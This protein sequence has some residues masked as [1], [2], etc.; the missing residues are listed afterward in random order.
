MSSGRLSLSLAIVSTLGSLALAPAPPVPGP[1]APSAGLPPIAFVSRNPVL[2]EDGHPESGAIPGIGLRD[3]TARVG[4][5]LLVREPD[6]TLRVLVAPPALFDVADPCVS[7]DGAKI[8][9]SGLAHPDSSWRIFEIA[10]E[11]SG[12]RQVTRSDRAISL[13][14]FGAAAAR[15]TRY[16]DIDPCWFPDGRICFASTRYPMISEFG[17]YLA[18]NLFVAG[19]DGAHPRRI[20]T[21]RGSG[22]EPAFDPITGRLVYSRWLIN[23]DRPSNASRDG[24]TYL[25]EQALTT[26][27]GNVWQ[28]I[29]VTP[30]GRVP[31]LHAGDPRSRVGLVC[32]KPALFPDGRVLTVFAANGAFAPGPGATGIRLFAPGADAGRTVIGFSPE[33]LAALGDAKESPVVP[34]APWATDP[35]PLPDG[36]LVVSLAPTTE[37]DFGL[38]ACGLDGSGLEP[39][40]DLPGTLELDAA[41]IAPRPRP[42]VLAGLVDPNTSELPPTED[43]ATFLS[44]GTYRFDCYNVFMNAPVD[45]PIPDAPPIVRGARIRFYMNFQRQNPGGRDPSILFREA[46]ISARG[47]IYENGMPADVPFFGQVVDA[48][49]RVVVGPTGVPAHVAEFGF[50]RH[51]GWAQCVGCH[52]G[53]SVMVIPNNFTKSEWFNVSTSA[54]VEASSEWKPRGSTA[55]PCPGRRVVDRRARNDSLE[56]AWVAAGRGREW[57]TLRWQIPIEVTRFV[58]YGIHSNPANGTDVAVEDCRITLLR[59]GVPV[60]QATA[61]AIAPEG[62]TVN[63]PATVIDSARIEVLRSRGLVRGEPRTGLAEVETIARL[64]LEE[65]AP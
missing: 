16:D 29:S 44:C 17:D 46:P 53:H 54:S 42:P 10:A 47:A 24:L 64:T 50:A 6:G 1:G 39:L 51:G 55:P 23:L 13:L 25:D 3:R 21:E 38:Y 48:R 31:K 57:V 33:A 28:T 52:V 19:T 60:G 56:V 43:P 58:L 26:D 5:R 32:Y 41:V 62:T 14:Q 12:L 2:D 8:V 35:E 65:P 18:T 63:V 45:A 27:V 9:F 22:E 37:G 36:R 40:V 11:G 59:G 49:G 61:G 30:D 7:W 15:F 20:T 34:A 4:G